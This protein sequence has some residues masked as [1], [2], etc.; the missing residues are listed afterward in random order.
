MLLTKG[1]TMIKGKM[2]KI[3]KGRDTRE[4]LNIKP[5]DKRRLDLPTAHRLNTTFHIKRVKYVSSLK[6]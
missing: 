3:I 2:F 6:W 5:G 4:R 1:S